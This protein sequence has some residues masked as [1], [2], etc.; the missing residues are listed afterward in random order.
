METKQVNYSVLKII[1]INLL[2]VMFVW[3]LL[4]LGSFVFYKLY[5]ENKMNYS[6]VSRYEREPVIFYKKLIQGREMLVS[7]IFPYPYYTTDKERLQNKILANKT[8]K[9]IRIFTYGGSSTAGS[10]FGSLGSFSRFLE[11][12]LKNIA[13]PDV[14]IE[15]MNFGVGG[16]GSTRVARLVERTIEYAPDLIIVYSGHNEYCDNAKLFATGENKNNSVNK[17]RG[18]LEKNSMVYRILQLTLMKPKLPKE[19]FSAPVCQRS[20]LTED[21]KKSYVKIYESNIKRII[22]SARKAGVTVVLMSQISNML[23]PPLTESKNDEENNN[24]YKSF[25]FGLI[26]LGKGDHGKACY[27]LTQ[28]IDHDNGPQ[29]FRSDYKNILVKLSKEHQNVYFVDAAEYI[30]RYA[31]EGIIDGRFVIDVVHPNITSNKLISE[32]LMKQ[33]FHAHAWKSDYLIYNAYD[34]EFIWK[35]EIPSS[36]YFRIC[37]RYFKIPDDDQRNQKCLEQVRHDLKNAVMED[38]RRCALRSWEFLYILG[39]ET[40]NPILLGEA[41]D[42]LTLPQLWDRLEAH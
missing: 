27:H 8:D 13:R 25:Q 18:I 4:E 20:P 12:Q 17:V 35:E 37:G 9:T 24:A 42:V 6:L 34:P 1:A 33:F 5:F 22:E 10:P 2:L 29:R 19:P 26:E 41:K 7:D 11:D 28:A 31:D 15:V 30:M 36:Q 39:S 14:V 16:F 3:G 40:E 38:E 32:S 21:Q 23:M